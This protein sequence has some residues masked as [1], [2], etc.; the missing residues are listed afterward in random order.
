MTPCQ[1]TNEVWK[2][3]VYLYQ[4]WIQVG[5]ADIFITTFKRKENLLRQSG[6]INEGVSE[7]V[8]LLL[9]LIENQPGLKVPELSKILKMPARTIERWINK[10]K[11]QSK[12]E[13]V[14]SLKS[15]G[16]Y[17]KKT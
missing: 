8:K 13:Y 3:S 12:I 7:G 16:Y 6:G 17:E 14:G 9:T 15:G 4:A 2:T 10:L 1:K 11:K 5:L